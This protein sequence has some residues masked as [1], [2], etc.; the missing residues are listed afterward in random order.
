[1]R[2]TSKW[3]ACLLTALAVLAPGAAPGQEY[4]P[5]DNCQ[6]PAPLYSTHPELGGLYTAASFVFYRQN[7]PLKSQPVA[8]EGFTDVDGSITG[9]PG[10]FVG[11][12]I[13]VLDVQ[14]VSGPQS[15]EP[16]FTI[17]VGWKMHDG[18]T[19]SVSYTWVATAQYRAVATLARPLL[20]EGQFLQNSF[21]SS[22]VFNFPNDFAGPAFKA[23]NIHDPFLGTITNPF[24]LFGIWNGASIMTEKY[25][26]RFQTGDLKYRQTVFETED[27]RLSGVVGARWAHIWDR[28]QWR[29]TDLDINGNAGPQDVAIYN[30]IT[31]NNMYGAFVGCQNE[32][33]VGKGFALGL[34]LQAAALLDV[35]KERAKYENGAKDNFPVPTVENK[36]AIKDY[37]F[38]PQL[39]GTAWVKWY[40]VEGVELRFGYDLLM[41]FNIIDSRQPIDFNYSA[42]DPHWLHDTRIF[43][44]FQ[45]GV[46]LV[47]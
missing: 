45:A 11:S 6:L 36:R 46:A 32:C 7:N 24:A 25:E 35:V 18:S 3:G 1:M 9:V 28:Y 30:E 14:Q 10:T 41:F 33:Y 5:P 20:Q 23:V 8:H 37:T 4:A 47:W 26:Q 16:G 38:V 39:C 29:T 21:L 22:D 2:T 31:S 34:D 13:N 15:Y 27:Y 43:D 17:D 19:L 12:H 42:L 40:P 44:G